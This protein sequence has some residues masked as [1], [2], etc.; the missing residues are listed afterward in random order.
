MESK[1]I[2]FFDLKFSPS[3]AT[4]IPSVTRKNCQKSTQVAQK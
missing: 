2:V 3:F 4:I 1:P